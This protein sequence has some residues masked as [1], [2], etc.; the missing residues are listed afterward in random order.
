MKQNILIVFGGV[1]SEHDVSLMSAYAILDNI[2][3]DKYIVHKLGVTKTGD[4]LYYTGDN[5]RI[6]DN[7]WFNFDCTPCVISPNRLHHGIILLEK[8]EIIR[9]EAVFPIIHGKNG[10]DGTLQGLLSFANIPYVGCDYTSSANCM[11]KANTHIL[12]DN[13]NI[14]TAKYVA[15]REYDY[16]IEQDSFISIVEQDI[17]YPCFVKPAKSGSSVGVSKA[18]NNKELQLAIGLAFKEDSKILVEEA[19]NGIELE[20]AVMGNTNLTAS[21]IGEIEPC[22][23]FYDY[24]AKYLA[25][26]TKTFIPARIEDSVSDTI[27][28][29]SLKAYKTMEC[30]GL[31]RVDFF[32]T[33]TGEIYLNEINTIPGFTSIS[34]YSQL[35]QASGVEFKTLIT[36][37]IEYAIERAE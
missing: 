32:L 16:S 23:D 30:S 36:S 26:K 6:K 15:I 1:S 10:E 28:E 24:D 27:R 9:I 18:T 5:H 37:L 13:A 3:K 8:N 12:L 19:I 21:C 29:L 35:M 22:N 31:A 7:T 14:K 17:L 33:P 34:M 20:C 25:M 2:D 4:M 11:D